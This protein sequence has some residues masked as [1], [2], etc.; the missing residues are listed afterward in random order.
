VIKFVIVIRDIRVIW[1]IRFVIVIRDIRVS[2]VI[3]F[4]VV[5]WDIRVIW[6]IRFAREIRTGEAIVFVGDVVIRAA[7]K[8]KL[9]TL[10]SN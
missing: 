4:V 10:D 8:L 7:Q 3:R 9:K 1:V 6:V 2:W 5:F